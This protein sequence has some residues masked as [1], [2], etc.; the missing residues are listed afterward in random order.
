MSLPPALGIF[1]AVIALLLVTIVIAIFYGKKISKRQAVRRQDT[2][3]GM[4]ISAPMLS[5]P[6]PVRNPDGL[7]F[8]PT[9]RAEKVTK[10]KPLPTHGGWI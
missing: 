7:L 5:V 3:K 1:L 8:V 10:I 4:K 6:K 9:T 2:E